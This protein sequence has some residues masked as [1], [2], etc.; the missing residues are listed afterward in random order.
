LLINSKRRGY[1]AVGAPAEQRWLFPGSHAGRHLTPDRLQVGLNRL[2][3]FVRDTRTVAL[4]N[5]AAD[6]PVG[7]L[8]DMLGINSSTA[9]R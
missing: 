3:I 5:L 7:V 8:V 1:A 6:V 4:L 2:G 9:A